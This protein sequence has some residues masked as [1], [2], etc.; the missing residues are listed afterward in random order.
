MLNFVFL[1]AARKLLKIFN[2]LSLILLSGFSKALG[3]SGA[4][5]YFFWTSSLWKLE[6]LKLT[7]VYL[8]P[9]LLGNV[10]KTSLSNYVITWLS[11]M[12]NYLR[13]FLP[14]LRLCLGKYKC[15]WYLLWLF[16][17]VAK[18]CKKR[19]RSFEVWILI[20]CCNLCLASSYF[21]SPLAQ[22]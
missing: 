4:M 19:N 8:K 17:K 15:L 21:F 11:I 16:W 5:D 6:I 20:A 3:V 18:R 7:V 2:F 14:P 12:K 10:H 9:W 13:P 22:F 1:D